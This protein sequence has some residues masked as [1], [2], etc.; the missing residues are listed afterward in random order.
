MSTTQYEKFIIAVAEAVGANIRL[1]VSRYIEL[2]KPYLKIYTVYRY[3]SAKYQPQTYYNTSKSLQA[4]AQMLEDGDFP[5]GPITKH[6]GEGMDVMQVLQDGLKT[7][8]VERSFVAG[9][10][11]ENR[12]QQE[13]FYFGDAQI[14]KANTVAWYDG[15]ARTIVEAAV[16]KDSM[17]QNLIK[18]I[19]RIEPLLAIDASRILG[20]KI[21]AQANI[22]KKQM[23]ESI[24]DI[25]GISV[26]ANKIKIKKTGGKEIYTFTEDD[27]IFR[28]T[29]INGKWVFLVAI[30]HVGNKGT[31]DVHIHEAGSF[32]DTGHATSIEQVMNFFKGALGKAMTF[33]K[34]RKFAF[35]TK[36]NIISTI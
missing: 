12:Y 31:D 20:V 30:P 32:T 25:T 33:L 14:T 4:I 1:D 13:V 5:N 23:I 34:L 9:V 2:V 16:R 29:G 7:L 19:S 22:V 28:I 10:I 11:R 21:E 6:T 36:G 24:H 26:P 17:K 27:T 8:T 35:D 3:W 18:Q 15:E